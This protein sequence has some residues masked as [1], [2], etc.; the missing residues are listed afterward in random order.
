M[1]FYETQQWFTSTM[2]AGTREIHRFH[3]QSYQSTGRLGVP[4]S[5]STAWKVGY[6]SFL[7]G[8][9]DCRASTWFYL[10]K[11]EAAR[12]RSVQAA[13]EIE[14]FPKKNML[15]KSWWVLGMQQRHRG[16]ILNVLFRVISANPETPWPRIGVKPPDADANV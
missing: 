11:V 14:E 6:A 8:S 9:S 12:I 4:Y 7:E 15:L 13:I 16:G 10:P 5:C 2:C 3:V 1:Q